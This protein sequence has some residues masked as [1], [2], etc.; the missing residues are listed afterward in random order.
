MNQHIEVKHFFIM[1]K[2]FDKKER[3]ILTII[4]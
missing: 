3:P 2:L 4:K 1:L